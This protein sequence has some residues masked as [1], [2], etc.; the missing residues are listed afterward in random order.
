MSIFRSA[1]CVLLHVGLSTVK[2][3]LA[4]V[5]GFILCCS[6]CCVLVGLGYVVC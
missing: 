3:N 6:L 1:D 5:V 4:L 2:D